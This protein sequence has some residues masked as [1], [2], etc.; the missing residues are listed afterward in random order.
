MRNWKI[1]KENMQGYETC[2]LGERAAPWGAGTCPLGVLALLSDQ[3]A[4][5]RA[6]TSDLKVT[7]RKC[8]F[9]GDFPGPST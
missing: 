9:M 7:W 3:R 8:G 4:P 6:G 2:S 1:W 5:R